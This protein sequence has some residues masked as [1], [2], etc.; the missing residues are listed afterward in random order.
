MV[1]LK[2]GWDDAI[3]DNLRPIWLSN[4]QM[5]QEMKNLRYKRAVV[6][7][8]AERSN[9]DTLDFGDASQSLACSAV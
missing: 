8:D 5:I 9:I 6:P 2:T 3:P 4:F 1:K 7:D